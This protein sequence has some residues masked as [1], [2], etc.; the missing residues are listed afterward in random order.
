MPGDA[1]PEGHVLLARLQVA[2][3]GRCGL[4]AY[5]NLTASPAISAV[6]AKPTMH[7]IKAGPPVGEGQRRAIS[8]SSPRSAFGQRVHLFACQSLLEGEA[9]SV[10]EIPDDR[11]R[12]TI[13]C[14]PR[15]QLDASSQANR[16]A[17]T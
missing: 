16:C 7:W 12:A 4:A 8:T 17:S 11:R 13:K 15:P 3:T 1:S 10:V 5:A 14:D 9:M 6:T 2:S